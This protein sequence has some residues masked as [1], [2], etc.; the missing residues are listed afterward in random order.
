MERGVEEEEKRR[1]DFQYPTRSPPP[2]GQGSGEP[3]ARAGSVN[4]RV[5]RPGPGATRRLPQLA[6]SPASFRARPCPLP[7]APYPAQPRGAGR[8]GPGRG[9]GLEGRG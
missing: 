4:P 2:R 6:A 7:G 5:S 1:A 3:S 9:G 8:A